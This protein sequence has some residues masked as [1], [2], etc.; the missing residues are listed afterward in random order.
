MIFN[1][2][3][4]MT[5][6]KEHTEPNQKLSLELIKSIHKIITKDTLGDK[7]YE[8]NFRMDN[9]VNVYS[10]EDGQLVHH[11]PEYG[12]ISSLLELL[13]EFVNGESS[14]L[15][16]FVQA[17]IIHYLIGYIH[18]F[19]DGNGRT[20]RALFYWYLLSRGYD[21]IEYVAVSTAIKK[22]PAQYMRAYL[23]C[24]TDDNDVTY[25]VI[26]CL[27]KF[28]LAVRLFEDYVAKKKDENLRLYETVRKNPELNFRQADILTVLG[29]S[30]RPITFKEMQERYDITYQTAR[31]DLLKLVKDGYLHM[32]VKGRQFVFLLK[33]E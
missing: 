19:N 32:V 15:H 9:E 33:K 8:G 3:A 4:T 13:C 14:Y 12:K 29:K 23:Y 27:E 21:Y 22:A 20:A 7:A 24:E 28:E 6:I 31:T 5:Y 17:S 30:E 16:P 25:F 10:R 1:N 18:P 2:Y 11:P 26:F